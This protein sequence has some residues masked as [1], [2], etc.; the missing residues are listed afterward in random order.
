[1]KQY[2]GENQGD[3][4]YGVGTETGYEQQM[5]YGEEA[6]YQN[7]HSRWNIKWNM[8]SKYALKIRIKKNL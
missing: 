5:R 8:G 6:G 1:M 4:G 7:M 2:Y 3:M